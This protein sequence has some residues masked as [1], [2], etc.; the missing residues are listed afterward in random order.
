MVFLHGSL[1]VANRKRNVF[2]KNFSSCHGCNDYRLNKTIKGDTEFFFWKGSPSSRRLQGL[3][4]GFLLTSAEHNYNFV[5]DFF[6][7][8][9]S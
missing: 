6:R 2:I 1:C 9:W 8:I 4:F 3:P 7:A 5:C